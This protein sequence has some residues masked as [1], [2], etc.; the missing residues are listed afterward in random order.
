MAES[1]LLAKAGE[2]VIECTYTESTMVPDLPYFSSQV[3]LGP[4]GIAEFLPLGDLSPAEQ[5]GLEK[6]K[7]LLTKN[8][9]AGVEFASNN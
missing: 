9:A 7:P 6:M 8:I 2:K 3:V 1:V 4:E 5:D